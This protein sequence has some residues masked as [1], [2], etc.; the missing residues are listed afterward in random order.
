MN[1]AFG[2]LDRLHISRAS[3]Y[4]ARGHGP[5][6]FKELSRVGWGLAIY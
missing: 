4:P 5:I 6:L 2:I 1:E 3:L